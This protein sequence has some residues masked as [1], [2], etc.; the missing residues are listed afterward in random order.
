M[1]KIGVVLYPNYSLQEITCITSTLSIWFNE[2]I[3][4]IASENIQKRDYPHIQLS[5]FKK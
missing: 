3:D 1:K 2:E 4:Y 5:L